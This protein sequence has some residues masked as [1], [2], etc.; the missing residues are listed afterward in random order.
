MPIIRCF[1]SVNP[2][3]PI[4]Y[5][6]LKTRPSGERPTDPL[7][8]FKSL[9]LKDE[10]INDLWDGQGQALRQWH[11]KRQSADIAVALNTGAGKTLV[12]L[13]IAQSLANETAGSVLY[14]CSSRQLVAQTAAKA[15]GYGIPITTYM[16]GEGA[17][18]NDLFHRGLAPCIAT[19]QALFNGKSIFDRMNAAAVVFDDAHAA[20]HI[21]RDQFTLVIDRA[22][23][24]GAYLAICEA[25]R[26]YFEAVGDGVSYREIIEGRDA[27]SLKFVPPFEVFANI[28]QV[29]ERLLAIPPTEGTSTL[30]VWEYLKDKLDLCAVFV[31][32]RSVSF[33]PPFIPIEMLSY[34][35]R[36]TRRVYLSATLAADDI[37]LRTFGRMPDVV[38]NPD[39]PAGECERM[40]LFPARIAG[41]TDTR[42]EIKAAT[43]NS[44]VL[45]LVPSLGRRRN[46]DD[47]STVRADENATRQV[48]EFR[49][50]KAPAGLVLTAR[51]DG[52][53]LPGDTCR[54]MV[55]DGVPSGIGPLEAYLW[56]YLQLNRALNSTI[57]TRIT[58]S[59]GRISRGM[60]D[61]GAVLIADEALTS[62]L[63]GPRNQQQ[64]P[65]FLR[66]QIRL[67][68]EFS[69]QLPNPA[70]MAEAVRDC[71]GRN[72]GWVNH[73][74]EAMAADVDETP[75]PTDDVAA[76]I[77]KSEANVAEAYW[78]RRYTEAIKKLQINLPAIY[79]ETTRGG[80][81]HELWVGH[82]YLLNGNRE[83]ACE[84]FE[85]AH[86][87]A[88]NIP[89]MPPQ[90]AQPGEEM[91][92]QV[93]RIREYLLS[94]GRSDVLRPPP[95]IDSDTSGLD[96]DATTAQVEESLRVL[97][98]YLG[99]ESYRPDKEYGTGP[100]VLWID[101]GRAL[102][103]DAKTGKKDGG[104]YQKEE[105]GQM[106]DH[107]QW[108]R[109]NEENIEEILPAFVGRVLPASEKANP[110]PEVRVIDLERVKALRDEVRAAL[111]DICRV[112]LPIDVHV[113]ISEIL[114][115]RGLNWTGV[116]RHLNPVQVPRP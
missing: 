100:D 11:E 14:A 67:G 77:A 22:E 25:F 12:G 5:D 105:F 70:S 28:G 76:L 106:L 9:R 98:T 19:Y 93:K 112:A 42:G 38:I 60:S 16:P 8:L 99:F 53:D 37:F 24:Q 57:A 103:M 113:K 21:I 115:A 72:E 34:F 66:R 58:Q 32:A 20:S 91:P 65:A 71:H 96:F 43:R 45:V 74:S 94:G 4:K 92:E 33:S 2:T 90:V 13:L 75:P 116:L 54:T 95:R 47:I 27:N 82:L 44:K 7:K 18:S 49:N 64:L 81:W 86:R 6:Q 48:E 73:Y 97:G 35:G 3:M 89:G 1:L 87:A 68:Y 39:T 101:E 108:V 84:L 56:R 46:W 55:L 61:F 109:N 26:P 23:H 30:F 15:D 79:A 62:W 114:E 51:Y 50:A 52:V 88:R 102:C 63:S 80:A 69:S 10:G 78:N 104:V 31:N 85:R 107:V 59:F 29:T 41:S 17:F 110:A 83:I 36:E 111:V 40:I